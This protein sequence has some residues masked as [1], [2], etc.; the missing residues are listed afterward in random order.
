VI[1]GLLLS[2]PVALRLLR[3]SAGSGW[4]R[5]IVAFPLVLWLGLLGLGVYAR[6]L[7]RHR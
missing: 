7:F 5:M 6:R 3:F 2:S 4:R 1:F